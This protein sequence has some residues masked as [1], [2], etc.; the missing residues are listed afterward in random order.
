MVLEKHIGLIE[1]PHFPSRE[2]STAFRVYRPRKHYTT[3]GDH[4][5]VMVTQS[6]VDLP[7]LPFSSLPGF[8][9]L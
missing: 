3:A 6:H 9:V 4:H 1:K 8:F 7:I 5:D 2:M